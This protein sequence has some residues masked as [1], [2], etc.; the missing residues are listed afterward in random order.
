VAPAPAAGSAPSSSTSS[1]TSTGPS[2]TPS[3]TPSAAPSSASSGGATPQG[4]PE[5]YNRDRESCQA[6]ATDQ[7]K[8]RRTVDYGRSEVFQGQMDRYGT[9]ALPDR[10]SDYSDTRKFDSYYGDCMAGR[11]WQGE[12]PIANKWWNRGIKF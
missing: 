6:Q 10:M 1:G 3:A 9:A 2:A 4:N 7:M 8:T 5:K 12:N 11:G